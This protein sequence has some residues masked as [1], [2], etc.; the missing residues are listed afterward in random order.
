M[1]YFSSIQV[2]YVRVDFFS[3]KGFTTYYLF[4]KVKLSNFLLPE[5]NYVV[6]DF[7]KLDH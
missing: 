4:I 5:L 1:H 7:Y 3:V 2:N 6:K